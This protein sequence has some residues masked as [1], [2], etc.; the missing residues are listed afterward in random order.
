MDRACWRWL[1][2]DES[3]EPSPGADPIAIAE[4]LDVARLAAR[5]K[6]PLPGRAAQ[7]RF[8]PELSFSRHF[9]PPPPDARPAAV[10]ALLYPQLGQW[11]VPLTVRPTSM[12]THAGQIS[13]PGGGIVPGESNE[14]AVLRELSE[15]L[16][17]LTDNVELL[18]EL[19]PLYLYNSNYRVTAWVAAVNERPTF[20]PDPR[21][22]AELLE[23][24]L[25]Q[26]LDRR[27]HGVTARRARGIGVRV[28][29]IAFGR[30]RIWGATS[31]IL[32]ELL[33][34]IEELGLTSATA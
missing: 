21:E 25:A 9:G 6:Q 27:Q 5:L 31:M 2:R 20:A 28:P 15:E 14:A 4:Q 16:G 18:G 24:P 8:E 17:F 33:A 10:V 23:V 30:H 29:H 13:F 19:T 34:I 11:H 12:Q 7:S 32:G 3:P 1:L 22:V 26:L